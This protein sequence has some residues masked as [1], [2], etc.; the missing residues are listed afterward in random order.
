VEKL[1]RYSYALK[2]D[3]HLPV[4]EP[5]AKGTTPYHI[6]TQ[7]M[8]WKLSLAIPEMDLSSLK[9]LLH[10]ENSLCS[11][12]TD[13]ESRG[14]SKVE[15]LSRFPGQLSTYIANSISEAIAIALDVLHAKGDLLP[16]HFTNEARSGEALTLPGQLLEHI[17]LLVE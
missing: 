9:P 16:T 15:I 17:L 4:E 1:L 7:V 11:G 14:L 13:L 2:K 12:K 8:R 5:L 6:E 10:H 3:D